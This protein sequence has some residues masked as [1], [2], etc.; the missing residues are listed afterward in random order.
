M[1]NKIKGI[2][3]YKYGFADKDTSVYKTKKGLTRQTILD[4][5]SHKNEPEWMLNFRLKAY[6]TFKKMKNPN[7]GP[8][9][10]FLKYDEYTYYIK[11]A[12]KSSKSWNEVP[13]TIRNTFDKLGLPEQEK[14]FF[15]GIQNGGITD[16]Y[17]KAAKETALK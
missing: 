12:D 2:D 5:S 11:P 1:E 16:I 13:E 7:F 6:E 14:K 17:Y 15:A 9:L 10:S 3:D 8:D 4:I